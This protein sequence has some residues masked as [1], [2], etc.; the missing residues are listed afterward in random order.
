MWFVRICVCLTWMVLSYAGNTMIILVMTSPSS[1][2]RA[3][4][5]R[6]LFCVLAVTDMSVITLSFIYQSVLALESYGLHELFIL[7][8]HDTSRE[9]SNWT[10]V[11][12]SLERFLCVFCPFQVKRYCNLKI[13]MV[14]VVL[15]FIGLLV[16]NLLFNELLAYNFEIYGQIFKTI[17]NVAIPIIVI[18]CITVSIIIKLR[19][20]S[21][22]V[23]R[24]T[25]A[26]T[27]VTSLLLSA[28]FCF[29]ITMIPL[30]IFFFVNVDR[31]W[32]GEDI[33]D[34]WS[35]YIALYYL[36]FVLNF[37]I[38]F[39]FNVHF[40]HDTLNLLGFKQSN[41]RHL[42]DQVVIQQ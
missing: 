25:I 12:I 27:Q 20:R 28:N 23:V 24:Q 32:K 5:T 42:D 1:Q 21:A 16:E 4:T 18:T 30:H 6:L 11:V 13:I 40:R 8:F 7:T 33:T 15:C 2:P 41:E 3:Q 39:T 35:F 34:M 14:V 17:L 22:Q 37:Y 26:Q 38:Y 29:L 9:F 19:L 31:L 10:L 36:N